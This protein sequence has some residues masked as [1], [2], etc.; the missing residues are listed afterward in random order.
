MKSP[1]GDLT[2][3]FDLHMDE[4]LGDVKYDFLVTEICDKIINC[5]NLL[6]NDNQLPKD[7]SLR[8]VYNKYLHPEVINLKDKRIW[9][10]LSSG[11]VMD[12]FQFNSDVG[13]QAAKS[14]KPNNPIEMMMANS[15][16]R[17]MGEKDKERPIDRYIRLKNNI[18]DW[19]KEVNFKKLSN[20]E[21]KILEKYYL[22]RYGTP[23]MQ[24]DL[25][26]ICM[27]KDIAHFSL[28]EANDA[29]KIVAKKQM[30]RIPELK[31]KFFSQC[32]NR[33]FGEYVWETTMGPQLG[34]SFSVLHSLAYSFVGIQTLIL[35]TEY[36][37]IYWNCACLITNSGG[38]E[39]ADDEDE[40]NKMNCVEENN[41]D[42]EDEDD[43]EEE[44]TTKKKKKARNTNYGKIST[45]IGTMQHAGISVSPPDINKS[46]FTFIPD[47]ETDTIIYGIKGINRIGNELVNEII[48]KRPYDSIQDFLSKVKVN[49]PQMVSLIK[50]GA[51][52]KFG[53]SREK[54]MYQYID[55]ITE[56]KQRLTLQN[57]KMLIEHNLIP[58]ELSFEIKVFNFNKYLKKCKDGDNYY[59]D[60]IAFPFYENN[61]DMDLLWYEG[62][63]CLINQKDWDKIYKK[64]MEP[65]KD[66]IKQNTS[67][68]LNKL[69]TELLEE[70]WN[71]YCDGSLSK[72]EMDSISFYYHEHELANIDEEKYEICDFTE[73][74]EEPEIDKIIY[75]KGKEIPLFKI[76][77][78]AGTVLDKN[79]TKN[80]ISLLT[81]YGVVNVKIYQSQFA[82][83]DRQISQKL[84]D[85]RKKIIEKSWFSRGNKLLITGIRRSD[86]F[87]P[88]KYKNS[89]YQDIIE[90]IKEVDGNDLVLVKDRADEE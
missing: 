7:M 62:E 53:E 67:E 41:L 34:Y 25:M 60:K 39:D 88:K 4:K 74:P 15:L 20:D 44:V 49:K 57:M 11:N 29:R 79:K 21:I 42:E 81:N 76:Y 54:V 6:Q 16:M 82:K 77:R 85:G 3:Q 59:L 22:P 89:K 28:K 47:V 1:S 58:E 86:T 65:V 12:V 64:Q 48:S 50:S 66:Y 24:E 18:N 33:N 80:S 46:S 27:D 19:Y 83:Y 87:I 30:N 68:L 26:L 45:A 84:P 17:L 43:D 75:M 90:L 36:P 37:S 23:A 8:Q 9:N 56:K 2:T 73:L 14:I 13:L 69:N 40:E 31:E 55:M 72:W 61:F 38:N 52:D 71:K 63:K 32:P 78:I 10:A 70:N 5:V 51:F 35:A